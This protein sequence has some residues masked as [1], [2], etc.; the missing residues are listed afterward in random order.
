MWQ[1]N[2]NIIEYLPDWF[3]KILDFQEICTTEAQQFEALAEEINAVAHNFFFQ[4]MDENAVSMWE[5]ILGIVPNPPVET[6]AFRQFRVLNRLSTRPPFTLG[7]LYQK[8]DEIIG[9]GLW[10]IT[11]D[12][13]NYTLYIE[14]SSENQQYYTEV[15]YTINKIKPAHIVFIN[16][17]LTVTGMTINEGV[18]LTDL[19]WNYKLGAWG[20]GLNPFATSTTKEVLVVPA[21]ESIQQ[22]F[23]N[24]TASSILDIVASARIN[25]TTVISNLTKEAQTNTAVIQYTVT[26]DQAATVTQLELLDSNSNVLTSSPVYVP[27]V[28]EAVFT[29]N[30]P[31]EEAGTNG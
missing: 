6:L 5:Q 21:A 1:L 16:K 8:L 2:S 4:T 15:L 13:P 28:G 23:L 14:S 19:T 27:V 25:G 24:S 7:F 31:V 18:E 10:T 26:E 12:Y 20:L 29:H 30:I 17:P 9:K 11:V 3:K 22:T